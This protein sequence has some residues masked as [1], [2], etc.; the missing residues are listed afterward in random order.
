M[1]YE[2]R[3]RPVKYARLEVRPDGKVVVTA[4]S[5]FDVD[6]FIENHRKWL[7]EKL[8][9]VE[10]AR[11]E[12][13]KGFPINGRFYHVIHGRKPKIHD[14]FETVVLPPMPEPMVSLLRERLRRE[15][16]ELIGEYSR[17]MGVEP[18]KIYV[19][20]GRSK[21]GS[22]SSRKNLSFNLRLIV[23]PE[24]LK[25]YVVV[26]ELAHLRY[27]NHSKAFW[28]LVG[29]FYPDYKTA[30]RELKHWWRVVELNEYWR[31]LEGRT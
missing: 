20:L 23:V 10:K 28:E 16:H 4:P 22:C 17:K 14:R 21:W 1:D 25:R 8:A 30:R 12:T 24:N 18:G 2:L 11:K 13:E 5:G 7:E 3:V 9:E 27:L 26:H 15:L 31:W 29:R 19:R 6:S